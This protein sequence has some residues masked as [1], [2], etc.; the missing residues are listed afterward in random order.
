[1]SWK[2]RKRGT[3]RQ[4]GKRFKTKTLFFSPKHQRLATI[5]KIDTPS[6]ANKSCEILLK[7]FKYARTRD[8][9]RAIKQATVCAANRARAMSKKKT[10]TPKE[11]NELM[12]IARIYETA[13]KSM[14]LPSKGGARSSWKTVSIGPGY[15]YAEKIWHKN[16]KTY[17]VRIYETDEYGKFNVDAFVFDRIL[18]PK[19]VDEALASE[20]IRSPYPKPKHV[21]PSRIISKTEIEKGKK[22]IS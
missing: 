15:D 19:D 10:I 8:V 20:F 18:D 22:M 13:Y 5:V 2:T 9:K 16:G 12:E 7:K 17:G 3:P 11:R 1:M 6:N 4:R 14:I 21:S